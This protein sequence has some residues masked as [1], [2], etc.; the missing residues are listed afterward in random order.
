M[1]VM[2]ELKYNVGDKI[3]RTFCYGANTTHGGSSPITEVLSVQEIRIINGTPINRNKRI[4]Q[5]ICFN[6]R[7]GKFETFDEKNIEEY[8]PV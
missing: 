6:E 3:K 5:Y 4:I 8:S 1:S 7:I 2:I